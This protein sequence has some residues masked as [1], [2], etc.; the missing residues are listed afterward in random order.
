MKI[1]QYCGVL[2]SG[3]AFALAPVA[4]QTEAG[5][6]RAKAAKSSA[7]HAATP[8]YAGPREKMVVA[9]PKTYGKSETMA[10][11]GDY[12]SHLSRCGNIDLQNA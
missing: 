10:L 6:P 9:M 3:A 4:A 7:T 12:F 2:L 1:Q 11:W 5:A 8:A